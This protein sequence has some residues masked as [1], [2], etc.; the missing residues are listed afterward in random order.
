MRLKFITGNK[1]TV[2]YD[3]WSEWL[4]SAAVLANRHVRM[5]GDDDPF[6][7]NETASVSLLAAAGSF[8]GHVSLA[9][10]TTAK[11]QDGASA[12]AE[13]RERLGRADLWLHTNEKNWAFEFK[14]RMSVGVSRADGRLK[15]HLDAARKCAFDVIKGP[16]GDPVAALIVSLY[17][18]DDEFMAKEAAAEIERFAKNKENEIDFCWK[19]RPRKGRRPTYFLFDLL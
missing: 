14:Q 11:L 10:C 9:E 7:Y 15:S 3:I 16:D 17:F 12:K 2:E 18:V 8:A 4:Y 6:A 19:L 13:K 5:W 1:S